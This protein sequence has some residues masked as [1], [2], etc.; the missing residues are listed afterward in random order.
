MN[1][2]MYNFKIYILCYMQIILKFLK[3]IK[4][5]LFRKVSV[6]EGKDSALKS[7]VWR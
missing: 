4:A 3:I 6:A 1:T 2:C 7:L 5:Q